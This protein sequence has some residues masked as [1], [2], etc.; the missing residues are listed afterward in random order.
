V[1]VIGLAATAGDA[2][3]HAAMTVMSAISGRRI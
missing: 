1:I 3:T 2:S